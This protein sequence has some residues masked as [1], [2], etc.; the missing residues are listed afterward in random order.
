MDIADDDRHNL[1]VRSAAD[2]AVVHPEEQLSAA[3]QA[4][5]DVS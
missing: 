3:R 5:E 4:L 1:T 2:R